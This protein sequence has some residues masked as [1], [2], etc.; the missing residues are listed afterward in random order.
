[1]T[2]ESIQINNGLFFVPIGGSD[3]IGMNCNVY[4]SDD[5]ILIVDLGIG[6]SEDVP[7][8]DVAI[9]DLSF[10]FSRKN[11]V[12]GI[13]ITHVHE[14]HCGA[15]T[16]LL[17][18]LPQV[19]IYSSRFGI[20]FM[21]AK[22]EENYQKSDAVKFFLIEDKQEVNIQNFNVEFVQ[23]THSTVEMMA[24]YIKTK[25][26]T[27]FH[28]GDWKFD[29][30]PV[31]GDP[32]DT[33]RLKEIGDKGID[34]MVSDST[35]IV[36]PGRAGSEGSLFD[37]ILDVCSNANSRVIITMFAS[38]VARMS[39][40]FSV[41]SKLNKK[42]CLVGRALWRVFNAA[43]ES[44]YL[45]EF[46]NSLVL[47]E[48][49]VNSQK[50]EN[51]IIVC[52]G[53]QAEETAA[54]TKITSGKHRHVKLLKNDLIVF[55][56]KNIPGNER[57]IYNLQN[58]IV[59]FGAKFLTSSEERK[60]HVSGHPTFDDVKDMYNLIRPR[61]SIPVHGEDIHTAKHADLAR[62]L[63]VEKVIVVHNG[64]VIRIDKD[65]SKAGKIGE[66]KSGFLYVD[67]KLFRRVN[68]PVLKVRSKI[69]SDGLMLISVYVNKKEK[70]EISQ[71]K[72]FAPG[73]L[74]ETGDSSI[75]SDF[76][77]K[78]E[79]EIKNLS[80]GNDRKLDFYYTAMNFTKKFCKNRLGKSPLIKIDTIFA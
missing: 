69:M 71:I 62:S 37:G 58:K 38:N 29:S 47:S 32:I 9:P 17:K 70:T 42:V 54:L 27:I 63:N 65:L 39:T 76:S 12:V 67:G 72:I 25:H 60:V 2:S 61:I 57:R 21:K 49:E 13:I 20:N 24:L 15:L 45:E 41:A 53:C 10:V 77:G 6:F 74:D 44:G 18:Y 8:V 4:I 26:G 78:L 30:D 33:E 79:K 46:N 52:T 40:I 50:P 7:G 5:Q 1:M 68:D 48:V 36:T 11:K 28:T 75:L 55:S 35:N 19:N 34:L 56:S 59:R 14:D 22:L 3:Q 43:I 80:Q 73:L 31:I 16:Y 51:L 23:L 66:V 64:D